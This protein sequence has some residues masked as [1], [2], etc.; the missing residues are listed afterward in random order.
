[1]K[2]WLLLLA[3]T[4]AC[5]TAPKPTPRAI[6]DLGATHVVVAGDTAYSIAKRYGV[7]VEDLIAANKLDDDARLSIGRTLKI[8]GRI[9]A[10][11]SPKVEATASST[12]AEPTNDEDEELRAVRAQMKQEPSPMLG[13]CEGKAPAS[14]KVSSAGLI[15]PLDGI[16]V[17]KFGKRDGEAHDG[18]DI[19]APEG[20]PFYAA[21]SGEVLFS[22]EQSGYGLLVILRHPDGK[23]SIYARAS[24]N[25][26]AAGQT[27]ERGA[28]VG[29][30]GK[31]AGADAPYLHFELRGDKGPVN[32]RPQLP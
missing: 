27:I 26:V 1:M 22:G 16:V 21:S 25:C 32:P 13:K 23:T 17:G 11:P 9:P 7:T 29:L 15:W 30:V 18:L 24:K 8:P 20:T 12:I 10:P 3:L 19:G 5:A 28:I 31:S 14:A 2:R 4:A 6:K